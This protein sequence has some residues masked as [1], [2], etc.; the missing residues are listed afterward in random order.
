[1]AHVGHE[2]N[3]EADALAKEGACVEVVAPHPQSHCEESPGDLF[4]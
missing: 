1:M 2:L 4:P 3:E